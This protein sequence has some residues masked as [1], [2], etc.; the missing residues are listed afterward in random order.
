MTSS[1]LSFPVS[2]R[3]CRACALIAALVAVFGSTRARACDVELLGEPSEA[4]QDAVRNLAPLQADDCELLR[5]DARE[6]GAHVTFIIRDGRRAERTLLQPEE[7]AP[8]VAALRVVGAPA[9]Q[10][11]APA[12]STPPVEAAP[13][14]SALFGA[15]AGVRAGA[16]KLVSPTLAIAVQLRIRSDWECGIHLTWPMNYFRLGDPPQVPGGGAAVNS[17]Q[18]GTE[19]LAQAGFARRQPIGKLILLVG[20]RAGWGMRFRGPPQPSGTS[21]AYP[22][23][24]Y[25]GRGGLFLGLVTPRASAHTRFRVELGADFVFP[26][27]NSFFQTIPNWALFA[28]VGIEIGRS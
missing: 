9:P 14:L 24:R 4:W 5:I 26:K 23:G 17:K 18:G 6:G 25:E 28:L 3:L 10:A 11:V 8:A 20:A 21:A 27:D 13:R 12:P 16:Q 2:R 15:F 22:P 1:V 7:L 19:F